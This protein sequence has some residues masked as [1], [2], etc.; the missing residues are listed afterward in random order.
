MFMRDAFV[1]DFARK[2]LFCEVSN[3]SYK[4]P[5]VLSWHL[6]PA[7][8]WINT[9]IQRNFVIFWKFE[10]FRQMWA[11]MLPDRDQGRYLS[12]ERLFSRKMP[13]FR[14]F[15]RMDF[16]QRYCE[17][18]CGEPFETNIIALFILFSFAR[19][20][21]KFSWKVGFTWRPPAS[22]QL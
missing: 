15:K 12:F 21:L 11:I 4:A 19:K 22:L 1:K 3:Y 10:N 6:T 2:S 16:R 8:F 7:S 13:I 9:N 18:F 17:N 20:A 14:K 5:S